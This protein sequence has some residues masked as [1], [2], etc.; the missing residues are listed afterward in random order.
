MF[1]EFTIRWKSFNEKAPN[2][3][4]VHLASWRRSQ[5][6]RVYAE[7]VKCGINVI[8]SRRKGLKHDMT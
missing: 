2:K 8:Y 5:T 6:T 1:D 3:S 4:S 7:W